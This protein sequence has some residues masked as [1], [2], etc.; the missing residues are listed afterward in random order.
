MSDKICSVT[1][2]LSVF[3]DYSDVCFVILSL[4]I[5]VLITLVKLLSCPGYLLHGRSQ[6]WADIQF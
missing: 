2:D 4:Y 1:Q 6:L 3:C 5:A